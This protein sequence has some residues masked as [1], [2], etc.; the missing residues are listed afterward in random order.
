MRPS[1]VHIAIALTAIVALLLASC[2]E[3]PTATS[4]PTPTATPTPTPTATPFP[5]DHDWIPPQDPCGPASNT[6]TGTYEAG[7]LH[8][9]FLHWSG[10][11]SHLVFDQA[12]TLWNVDT[13]DG[14]ILMV[15]DADG[16]FHAGTTT[17]GFGNSRFLYGFYAD[18]SPDGSQ[19]VY[20][21]CEFLL[22]KQMDD[23]LTEG[24][25]LV[26]INVDGTDKTRLTRIDRLDHYPVWS[27]DGKRIAFVT[28]AFLHSGFYPDS[29]E[30]Q[31][32]IK[33]ATLNT[34]DSSVTVVPATSRVALYPPV[35]TP[36]SQTLAYMVNEGEESRSYEF[37]V[38]TVSLDDG[39]P[40]RIGDAVSP[41]TWSPDGEEL[42]LASAEGQEVVVYAAKSDGT[43]RREVWRGGYWFGWGDHAQA[44]WSPDGSEI[45]VVTDQ[46]FLV[47]ADGSEQRALAPDRRVSHAA[48][49]PDGSMIALRDSNSISIVSRDGTDLRVLAEAGRN[50]WLRTV[51]PT[52]PEATAEPATESPTPVPAEPTATPPGTG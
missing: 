19:I 44:H 40:V 2:E 6:G 29:P 1:R 36:D 32:W 43:G 31:D 46:A 21:S 28:G 37:G 14:T 4:A 30:R 41:P 9:G 20:S 7:P 11:G 27:P 49:S 45:L 52:Q 16:D 38:W 23:R 39:E 35:W 25:E 5:D 26:T 24:Y 34:E 8:E 3:A 48:W 51:Q 47:S 12:D 17:G 33:L 50:G 13:E 18:V 42:A 10:D 15:A 22:A